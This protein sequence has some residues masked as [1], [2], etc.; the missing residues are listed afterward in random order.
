MD[1]CRAVC[2]RWARAGRDT[3]PSTRCRGACSARRRSGAGGRPA[4]RP[5]RL[6]WLKQEGKRTIREILVYRLQLT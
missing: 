3:P 5:A 4:R 1:P 6:L 2:S